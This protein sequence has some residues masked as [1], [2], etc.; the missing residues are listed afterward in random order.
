MPKASLVLAAVLA[1]SI[2]T[3]GAGSAAKASA[4]TSDDHVKF[5]TNVEF[6]RGHLEKAVMNK[7]AGNNELATAHAGHPVAEVYSLMTGEIKEHDAALDEKLNKDLNDLY[8]NIG[9][10]SVE[11]VKTQAASINASLDSAMEAIVSASERDDPSFWARVVIG[12]L[13]TSENEYEEGIVNGAIA[14]QIEYQ[15]ASAFMHRAQVVFEN[16]KARMPE[17][18]AEEAKEF[19]DQLNELVVRPANPAEVETVLDGISHKLEE[20]FKL[21]SAQASEIGGWEYIDKINEL[22]GQSITEYKEGNFDDAKALAREAYLDNY[23]NIESDI[24]QDNK[25]LMEKIETAMRVDLVK[26]IDDRKPAGD[27]QR[28]IDQIRA[29]LETAKAVVTPEFPVAALAASLGIAGTIAYGR[30][31][32]FRRA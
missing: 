1:F 10:M 15:D 23:E 2:F 26:M 14:E 5:A 32:G 18:E 31:V 25:P 6:I 28:H 19:F 8:S 9:S 12:L 29:D 30:L 4:Q 11:Q 20:A 13:A 27:I 24:A 3:I 21:E 22:L 7:E 17:H 16:I